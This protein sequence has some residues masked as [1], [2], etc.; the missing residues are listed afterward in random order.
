[1]K[2]SMKSDK[3]VAGLNIV[4]GIVVALFVIGFIAMLFAIIGGEVEEETWDAIAGSVANETV[5]AVDEAGD[6]LT[7]GQYNGAVCTIGEVFEADYTNN[8]VNSGN[9][10]VTGC[11]LVA[12]AGAD[13]NGSDWNV[14]YSYTGNS[15]ST[16]S[17]II[18]TTFTSLS[19]VTSWQGLIIVLGMV[20]VLIILTVMIVTAI[21][22]AGIMGGGMKSSGDTTTA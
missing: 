10:T 6:E 3:G 4:A 2:T 19:D 5:T 17:N 13:Y 1:M 11:N 15:N 22:N 8:S 12:N 20:V 7:A 21:K 14:S 9:Y 18:H 16:S